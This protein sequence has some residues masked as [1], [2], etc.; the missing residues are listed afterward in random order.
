MNEILFL[1][2]FR[3][4]ILVAWL[5]LSLWGLYINT[6]RALVD[7][8]RAGVSPTPPNS[9]SDKLLNS[10]LAAPNHVRPFHV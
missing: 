1:F 5:L 4:H 9:K 10:L 8:V 2:E 7:R 3:Y 6:Y